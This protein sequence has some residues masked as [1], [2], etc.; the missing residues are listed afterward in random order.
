MY[1]R[2][3]SPPIVIQCPTVSHCGTKA[4]GC[5]RRDMKK[6][7]H[8]HT[9][10]HTHTNS[11]TLAHSLSDMRKHYSHSNWATARG[12]HEPNVAQQ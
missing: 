11:H 10:T 5:G 3:L 9:H 2:V 7:M 4:V 1:H 6:S 12:H 8:T